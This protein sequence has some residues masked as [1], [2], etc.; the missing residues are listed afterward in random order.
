MPYLI[1]VPPPS[2]EPEDFKKLLQ[3]LAKLPQDDLTVRSAMRNARHMLKLSI[4]FHRKMA[5]RK[6]KQ[7]ST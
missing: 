4:E 2:A 5:S 6:G 7:A 1:D 3:K